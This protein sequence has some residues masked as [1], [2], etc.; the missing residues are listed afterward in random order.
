MYQEGRIVRGPVMAPLDVFNRKRQRKGR[1]GGIGFVTTESQSWR[2]RLLIK[3]AYGPRVAIP[4][5]DEPKQFLRFPTTRKN[6]SPAKK[7]LLT[8]ARP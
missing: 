2:E 1:T 6:P 5:E 3:Y 4:R 8:S 7:M